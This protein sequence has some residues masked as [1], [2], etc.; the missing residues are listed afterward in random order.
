M[1]VSIIASIHKQLKIKLIHIID[2]NHQSFSICVMSLILFGVTHSEELCV[3]KSDLRSF[4]IILTIY[5]EYVNRRQ[6][7][8]W[9]I[10]I[11]QRTTFQY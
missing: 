2:V 9:S 5:H 4:S 7:K 1:P 6:H 8:A 3:R 11:Q 10:V